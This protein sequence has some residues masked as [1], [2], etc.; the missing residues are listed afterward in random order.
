MVFVLSRFVFAVSPSGVC[1][2]ASRRSG[3]RLSG[4][5]LSACLRAVVRRSRASSACL[6][7]VAAS[8]RRC[9]L[10]A[11]VGSCARCRAASGCSSGSALVPV[12]SVA[13]WLLSRLGCVPVSSLS[14]SFFPPAPPAPPAPASSW[15]GFV[16]GL[17]PVS[18][19]PAAAASGSVLLLGSPAFRAE[20]AAGGCPV[21]A[22]LR[23]F[24]WP[25]RSAVLWSLAVVVRSPAGRAFVASPACRSAAASF[26][27]WG[28][29]SLGFVPVSSVWESAA[30]SFVG[31]RAVVPL[32]PLVASLSGVASGSAVVSAFSSLSRCLRWLS[33]RR[34]GAFCPPACR[35]ALASL[36]WWVLAAL[37]PLFSRR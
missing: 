33:F 7:V 17:P 16:S 34:S 21:A 5:A 24:S 30:W 31:R 18:G 12:S 15:W 27:R 14:S 1:F 3:R 9:C 36:L 4:G 28:L 32:P 22:C 10:L 20:V 23:R 19:L 6:R 2:V 11:F 25:V 29:R 8:R 13:D 26:L 37:S 35:P